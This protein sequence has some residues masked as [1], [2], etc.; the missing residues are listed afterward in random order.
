MSMLPSRYFFWL[1]LL[2]LSLP[3][4][5]QESVLVRWVPENSGTPSYIL[6]ILHNTE[7]ARYPLSNVPY[8]V[9]PLVNTVAFEWLEESY[10]TEQAKEIMQLR[11]E[12]NLKRYLERDDNIRY[13]LFII[14]NLQENVEQ[15]AG[16]MPF[17]TMQL[18]R[19]FLRGEGRTY[20]E[21]LLYQYALEET[22]PVLSMLSMRNIAEYMAT[23]PSEQQAD[24]LSRFVNDQ[25]LFATY[26]HDKAGLYRNQS[27]TELGL[28]V[29]GTEQPAWLQAMR[30]RVNRDLVAQMMELSAGQSVLYILDAERIGGP[31]GIVP[32]LLEEG[33]EVSD[34]PFTLSSDAEIEEY[35]TGTNEL[36][37][38]QFP[39][40][41][42]DN[43]SDRSG[44]AVRNRIIK[45]DELQAGELPPAAITDPFGDGYD[46]LGTD[47]SFISE[48]FELRS[49]DA[50]FS[51]RMPEKTKWEETLTESINGNIKSVQAQVNHARSDLF[52]S[53][54][55]TIYPPNFD[56]GIRADF[57]DDFVYRSIRK[58]NGQ[59][60]TQRIISD[61]E[62][63][64][65]EFVVSVDDSFYV[66]SQIILRGNILYQILCGGPDNKP[67]APYAEEFIR[68]FRLDRGKATNWYTYL[69]QQISCQ[70]PRQPLI[71][72]QNYPTQYG[73][74][75]VKTFNTEDFDTQLSYFLS[76]NQYPDGYPV[77]GS[78]SFY[79]GL[80]SDAERQY[81]GRAVSVTKVRKGRNKGV[82]AVLQLNNGKVYRMHF[83]VVDKVLYQYLVG[84]TASAMES[85]GVDYFLDHFLI[86][87]Q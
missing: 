53:I 33:A 1:A 65:R 45:V 11:E 39:E 28:L 48:W 86:S 75:Q 78:K 56:P 63:V 46:Y 4:R 15:Y 2:L 74:V 73:Q 17:Y 62:Y 54:G 40:Y 49:N 51:I 77:K 76:I 71:Q 68:S 44:Y 12:L 5:A 16:L 31:G 85:A 37:A 36:Q 43:L 80:I 82:E 9:F 32:L 22:K 23:V 58:I 7:A 79:N 21:E 52:Y 25:D 50:Y 20:Q 6:A 84:G 34:M 26:E 13:E 61:P 69:D 55:Y 29:T 14:N 8:E 41:L 3:S 19:D 64:G 67:Y 24:V 38:D 59:L 57:F 42:L 81:F 83:F 27:L 70:F 87:D 10:E 18:F 30:T 47:T 66:R 35:Y 72:N 60:V